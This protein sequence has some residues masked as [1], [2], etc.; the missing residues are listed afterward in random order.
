MCMSVAPGWVRRGIKTRMYCKGR[1]QVGVR[2]VKTR[3]DEIYVGENKTDLKDTF[4][5]FHLFSV[6]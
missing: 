1:P 5:H 3:G 2:E 4:C 6:F